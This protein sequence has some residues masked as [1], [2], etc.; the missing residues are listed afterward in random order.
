VTKLL[1]ATADQSKLVELQR[2]LDVSLG[3]SRTTLVGLGEFAGCPDVPETKLTFGVKRADQGAP[4]GPACA[5]PRRTT[6]GQAV[7]D[8]GPA[9]DAMD[10]MPGVFVAPEG[11]RRVVQGIAGRWSADRRSRHPP[12]TATASR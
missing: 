4:S 3:A 6:P 7:D 11:V 9:V 12:R 8:S 10:G 5:H 2:I 1:L